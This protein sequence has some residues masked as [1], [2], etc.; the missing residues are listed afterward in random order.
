MKVAY[1]S[2]M[3][4]NTSG[5]ADYSALL[6]PELAKLIDVEVISEPK[7]GMGK[8]GDIALYHVG[9]NPEHH[10]WIVEALRERPGLVV[11]HEH[12]L[13]HLVAGMTIALGDQDGYLR[14]MQRDAGVVGRLMAHG[15]IDGVVPPVW[16]SRP[17]DFPLCGEILDLATGLIVHSQ[18][19]E[20]AARSRGY[21]G[22][23]YRIPHPAWPKPEIAQDPALADV[24][25]PIFGAFGHLNT[26][27]RAPQL[28]EAF[29][30]VVEQEPEAKLL[31]VG[32]ASEEIHIDGRLAE[33]EQ[34]H[35]G[36]VIRLPYVEEDRL[37]NLIAGCD[38]C[39][40]LR[41]PT[42]GETSGIAIRA[43]VCGRPLIVSDVGWFSELADGIAVR[44]PVGDG[45][46]AGIAEQMTA[47]VGNPERRAQ[48]SAAAS[49]YADDYLAVV[50]V[51]EQYR[52][53]LVDVAG[54]DR[55]RTAVLGDV[56]AA[57]AGTGLDPAGAE[58]A[59]IAGQLREVRV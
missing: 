46:V 26:A 59:A 52:R 43:L 6:V 36:S 3:P 22:P 44:V 50:H 45:E 30:Q 31:L 53:A 54:G 1:F 25:G 27:K 14:A 51:A 41:Y 4:P 8:S 33:I 40:C 18:T 35:A 37:W 17:M 32:S 57:S 24:T 47:L 49:R 19:V 21:V 13:H 39:V 5:I 56:A 58:V 10:G 12:V 55:V 7:R 29:A 23:I 38:V 16:E 34:A 20:D 11:L 42:M 9:N 48:M 28:V 15:I 2:P